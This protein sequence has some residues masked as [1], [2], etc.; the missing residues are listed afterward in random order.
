MKKQKGESEE[1]AITSDCFF[2]IEPA[3]GQNIV[4]LYHLDR[5]EAMVLC[6]RYL[7][8]AAHSA[9]VPIKEIHQLIDRINEDSV[10][11]EVDSE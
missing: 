5:E 7:V 3:E 4:I 6:M 2:C 8:C 1:M 11:V 10:I 9:K